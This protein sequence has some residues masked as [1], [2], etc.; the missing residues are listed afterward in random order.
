M[1]AHFVLPDV[2]LSPP[3]PP[4]KEALQPVDVTMLSEYHWIS[5]MPVFEVT[6]L[7]IVEPEKPSSSL[8][9]VKHEAV[10]QLKIVILSYPA[11]VL[12]EE[13]DTVIALGDDIIAHMLS[14]F[15]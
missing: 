11:S 10:L 9:V 5:I 8:V 3:R 2:T 1:Q 7:G 4:E 13:N 15:P 14:E 12:N 6:G